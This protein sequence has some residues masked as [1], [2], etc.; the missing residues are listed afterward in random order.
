MDFIQRYSS[1]LSGI[2]L[3]A[4][5]YGGYVLFFAPPSEPALTATAAVTAEDQELITLLLSL[6]NI[7]LDESLFSDPLFLAL[8]DFGQELVAE[9]VGRTNPFAPLTGGERRAP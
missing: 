3:I 9:P 8:K 5:L 6:K 2:A 1:V 4:V 7:R